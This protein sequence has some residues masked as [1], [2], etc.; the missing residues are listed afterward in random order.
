MTLVFAFNKLSSIFNLI[1]FRGNP[2][3]EN[4]ITA[5]PDDKKVVQEDQNSNCS[6]GKDTEAGHSYL[7]S[8]AAH[9]GVRGM[10]LCTQTLPLKQH[11]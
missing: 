7:G 4:Y 5:A 11:G 2:H 3:Q 1:L 9:Q 10:M 6:A 8:T